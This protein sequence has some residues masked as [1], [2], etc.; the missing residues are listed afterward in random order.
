MV[1]LYNFIFLIILKI[2]LGH[3]CFKWDGLVHMSEGRI[4]LSFELNIASWLGF[5]AAS[6]GSFSL[7]DV[8]Y[9]F[10]YLVS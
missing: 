3:L 5:E 4:L 1:V 7:L 10:Y 6:I 8:W 9:F 2:H